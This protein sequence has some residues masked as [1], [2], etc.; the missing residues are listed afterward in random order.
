VSALANV[1]RLPLASRA[2]AAG[3]LSQPSDPENPAEA[4]PPGTHGLLVFLQRR[5]RI[6][7]LGQQIGQHLARAGR[8][9]AGNRSSS[10]ISATEGYDES[11]GFTTIFPVI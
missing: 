7:E 10:S 2:F 1:T 6:I 9:S 3:L 4:V 8:T 5:S 11:A